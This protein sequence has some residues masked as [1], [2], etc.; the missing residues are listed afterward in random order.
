[1]MHA[2]MT[3]I[4]DRY[5]DIYDIYTAVPELCHGIAR[6]MKA[7][8]GAAPWGAAPWGAAR[9]RRRSQP[10]AAAPLPLP[11][12]FLALALV[13][14]RAP[15][16]GYPVGCWRAGSPLAVHCPPPRQ[17]TWWLTTGVPKAAAG[18]PQQPW[19]PAGGLS[20]LEFVRKN[21]KAVTRVVGFC[22]SIVDNGTVHLDDTM[23]SCGPQFAPIRA[24]G[25]EVFG[26]G[27]VS[28]PA[29]LNNTWRSGLL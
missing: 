14:V 8:K 17:A 12:L 3:A 6:A 2:H 29:L 26:A 18:A 5:R 27:F 1:M 19:G 22:W 16:S 25:V 9:G 7:L 28:V 10:P 4:A 20:N 15:D 11:L 23:S 24:L 21:R 13:L